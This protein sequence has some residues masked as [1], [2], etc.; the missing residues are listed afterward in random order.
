VFIITV[1]SF[2]ACDLTQIFG[3][4]D[5]DEPNTE[6]LLESFTF[7]IEDNASLNTT[8]DAFVDQETQLVTARLPLEV[9]NL[10]EPLKATVTLSGGASISPDPSSARAYKNDVYY[11]VTAENGATRTYVVQSS[12]SEGAASAQ[13]VDFRFL[14]SNPENSELL[15]DSV[16]TVGSETIYVILPYDVL[17]SPSLFLEPDIT[18]TDGAS[19]TPTGVQNFKNPLSYTVTGADGRSNSFTITVSVDPDSI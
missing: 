14:A 15:S 11:T 5:D 9:V 13:V 6:A 19:Y 18:V 7:K 2:V 10:E 12:V 3:A 4:E 16:A 1:F 17:Q 8:I